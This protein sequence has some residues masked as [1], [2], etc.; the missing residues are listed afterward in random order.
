MTLW[1]RLKAWASGFSADIDSAASIIADAEDRVMLKAMRLRSER[2]ALR[3]ALTDLVAMH[4][5]GPNA[6][7]NWDIALA[8]ADLALSIEKEWDR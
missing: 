1:Q 5:G 8:E 3:K 4:R 7:G 6:V 2:D